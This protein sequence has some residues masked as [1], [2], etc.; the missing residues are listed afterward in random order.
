[1]SVIQ[2]SVFIENKAGRI[3]EITD[4]LA[5]AQLNIRGFAVSDTAEYGI[6]RVVVD[7]PNKGKEALTKAGFTVKETPVI[8]IDMPHDRPGGLASALK[9]VSDAGVNIEYVY[10][11]I[12][13]FLAINVGDV[14]KATELLKNTNV[15]LVTPEQIAAY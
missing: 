4:T 10:S 8:V 11:L 1:M 13:T 2:L 15:E 3:T 7:N 9:A 5:Q 6:V 12:S 14:E